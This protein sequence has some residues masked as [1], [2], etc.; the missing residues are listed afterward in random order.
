VWGMAASLYFMLTGEPPRDFPQGQDPIRVML[1]S[2]AVPI[3]ERD[4]NVPKR[5]AKVIDEALV[6][7]PRITV[8][9]AVEFAAALRQAT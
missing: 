8:G 7:N 9:S 4:P 6:D 3:R 5:L 1:D 2:T